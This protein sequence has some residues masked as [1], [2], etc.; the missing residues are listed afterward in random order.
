LPGPIRGWAQSSDEPKRSEEGSVKA[1]SL[2]QPHAIAI[3]LRLKPFE[4]RGWQLRPED[5]GVPIAIHASLKR[6]REQDYPWDYFK[7]VKTRLSEAGVPLWRL[8]YGKVVCICTFKHCWRIKADPGRWGGAFAGDFW[9][10]FRPV[11]D[12]GKERFVF[13]CDEVRLIPEGQRPE[14]KGHQGFFEVPNEIGLWG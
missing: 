7:E 12:D 3:G 6:F 8:D 14:I 1:L 11:G 10:D 4:T 5:I 9:G 2:W 13:E